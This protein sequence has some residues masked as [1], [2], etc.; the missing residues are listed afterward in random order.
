MK[1]AYQKAQDTL[2]T[3]Q[4]KLYPLKCLGIRINE[5]GEI[6][7]RCMKTKYILEKVYAIENDLFQELELP[8]NWNLESR[9]ALQLAEE[10]ELRNSW[11]N[12]EEIKEVNNFFGI[13]ITKELINVVGGYFI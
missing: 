8:F 6:N 1:T 12:N 3:L 2:L 9:I 5:N 13:N 11:L 4:A 10:Q 7:C